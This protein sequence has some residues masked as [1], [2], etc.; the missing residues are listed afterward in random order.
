MMRFSSLQPLFGVDFPSHSR[1]A[2]IALAFAQTS[3]QSKV[4]DLPILVGSICEILQSISTCLTLLSTVLD[5]RL[6]SSKSRSESLKELCGVQ[7][8]DELHGLIVMSFVAMV[9]LY[10]AQMIGGLVCSS[11]ASVTSFQR[12]SESGIFDFANITWFLAHCQSPGKSSSRLPHRRVDLGTSLSE[13]GHSTFVND[14]LSVIF[15]IGGVCWLFRQNASPLSPDLHSRSSVPL[16]HPSAF[17]RRDDALQSTCRW[18]SLVTEHA[19]YTPN[20]KHQS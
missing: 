15:I 19:C 3:V 4:Q 18:G 8:H 1:A 2:C 5:P 11:Q 20:T 16:K 6:T 14:R 10:S 9:L 7:I 12:Y 17:L 13:H